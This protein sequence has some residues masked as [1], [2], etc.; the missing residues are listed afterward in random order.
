MSL[1]IQREL[2][3]DILRD[4]RDMYPRHLLY[5]HILDSSRLGEEDP[6]LPLWQLVMDWHALETS[7]TVPDD[8]VWLKVGYDQV[9]LVI[10]KKWRLL[11]TGIKDSARNRALKLLPAL[12]LHTDTTVNELSTDTRLWYSTSGI[13]QRS[14]WLRTWLTYVELQACHLVG[15][16]YFRR[17]RIAAP[18]DHLYPHPMPY[19]SGVFREYFC[20]FIT[21]RGFGP[22]RN[23]CEQGRTA[24]LIRTAYAESLLEFAPRLDNPLLHDH[25]FFVKRYGTQDNWWS[26]FVE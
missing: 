14:Q 25:R 5:D 20:R 13:H 23:F 21:S 16:I 3:R 7:R 4:P 19:L 24:R 2:V 17:H 26:V 15:G 6:R 1:E 9:F 18:A 11:V 12:L 10:R 22:T 8:P